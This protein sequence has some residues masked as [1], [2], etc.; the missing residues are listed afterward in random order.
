MPANSRPLCI[1]YHVRKLNEKSIVLDLDRKFE[2]DKAQY[3]FKTGIKVTQ[4]ALS[5]L[6]AI[7]KGIEFIVVLDLAKEYDN[8]L[9]VLM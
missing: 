9:K 4:A 6:S 8:V 3:G 5:V 2:T 1:L 7:R